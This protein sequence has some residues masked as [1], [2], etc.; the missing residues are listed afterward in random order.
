MKIH[1]IAT[2]ATLALALAAAPAF[3]KKDKV[4]KGHAP[5]MSTQG[6]QNT[7]SAYSADR[8]KGQDR[9]AER[10]SDSGTTHTHSGNPQNA[11]EKSG[12]KK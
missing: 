7:N 8:D 2:A 4:E 6:E 9:A 5:H 11:K 1:T 12:K 10:M 3:A